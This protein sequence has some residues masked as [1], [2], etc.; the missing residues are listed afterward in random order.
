MSTCHMT[1]K[2]SHA[3]PDVAFLDC[4][5]KIQYGRMWR[6]LEEEKLFQM[7][8]APG[9]QLIMSFSWTSL[10]PFIIAQKLMLIKTCQS[11]I[12]QST[13]EKGRERY[14]M[15][16]S[17]PWQKEELVN[18]GKLKENMNKSSTQTPSHKEHIKPRGHKKHI[19]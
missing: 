15:E 3:G 19:R 8:E 18:S 17:K 6:T 10:V 13:Q 4:T 14:K 11:S 12:K 9:M 7:D 2:E 1:L 16:G 5:K